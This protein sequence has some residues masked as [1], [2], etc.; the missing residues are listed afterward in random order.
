MMAIVW[1]VVAR[2]VLVMPA[3]SVLANRHCQ[4]PCWLVQLAF[5]SFHRRSVQGPSPTRALDVV[6]RWNFDAGE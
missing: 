2:A 5:P 4:P 6:R 3:G 1:R